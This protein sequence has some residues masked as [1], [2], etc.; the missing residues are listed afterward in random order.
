LN[1]GSRWAKAGKA[2]KAAKIPKRTLFLLKDSIK[3]LLRW[4]EIPR[5]V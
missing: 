5:V 2:A 1:N 3:S 4:A